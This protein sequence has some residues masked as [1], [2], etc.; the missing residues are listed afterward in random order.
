MVHH[1]EC[2]FAVQPENT[3][4][5]RKVSGREAISAHV[6]SAGGA[7]AAVPVELADGGGSYR[8]PGTRTAPLTSA[9]VESHALALLLLD[10]QQ[11]WVH[12]RMMT[13]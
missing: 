1:P 10:E 12:T 2:S 3:G 4:A 9:L 6:A 7:A 8:C 11:F 13:C 5:E